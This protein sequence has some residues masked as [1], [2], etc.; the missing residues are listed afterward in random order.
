MMDHMKV[1]LNVPVRPWAVPQEDTN[2][3]EY[4]SKGGNLLNGMKLEF[5]DPTYDLVFAV[6]SET[7]PIYSAVKS[8]T[9]PIPISF[10]TIKCEPKDEFTD[11]DIVEEE[12]LDVTAEDND[13]TNRLNSTMWYVQRS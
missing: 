13:S 5:E 9:S 7:P 3:V 11:V 6:K 2:A 1:E 10:P 12:L 4:L 8:E